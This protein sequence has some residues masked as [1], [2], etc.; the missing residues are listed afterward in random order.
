[1]ELV[2][3]EERALFHL[4]LLGCYRPED[5]Q[6]EPPWARRMLSDDHEH[7]YDDDGTYL[8][9]GVVTCWSCGGEGNV[10]DCC[11]NLCH[12]QDWCMHGDNRWCGVCAGEGVL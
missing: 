10:V 8:G 9:E 5:A 11:D 2:P 4:E 7:D 1:M 3:F 6:L 12:G